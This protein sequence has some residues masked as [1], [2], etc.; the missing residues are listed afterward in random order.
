MSM[1]TDRE[2]I[3]VLRGASMLIWHTDGTA[4]EQACVNLRTNSTMEYYA[5]PSIVKMLDRFNLIAA[6]IEIANINDQFVYQILKDNNVF[7]GFDA[8]GQTTSFEPA[9]KP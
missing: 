6:G 2:K 9:S 7:D 5:M 4:F 1:L 3:Q 8:L